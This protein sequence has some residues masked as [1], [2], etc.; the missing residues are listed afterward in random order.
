MPATE[1]LIL[2]DS[3]GLATFD[4]TLPE[5][6]RMLFDESER[7]CHARICAGRSPGEVSVGLVPSRDPERTGFC[8][9]AD[10]GPGVLSLA[11]AALSML[12][13]EVQEAFAYCR[14]MPEPAV[15]EVLD[16]FWLRDPSHVIGAEEIAAF[17][18]LF[19]EYMAGRPPEMVQGSYGDFS[20]P[21][22]SSVR[23]VS[24]DEGTLTI[25]EVETSD[26]FGLLWD[27]SRALSSCEL[28]ILSSEIQT[29]GGR[30]KDTFTVVEK[31][32]E[33]ISAERRLHIQATVLSTLEK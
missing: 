16:I 19:A 14:R 7:E 2:A 1:S 17:G 22:G 23:F 15:D 27:I 18:N 5:R 11:S 21:S 28:L 30:V 10:D 4:A 33:R 9:N 20:S 24:N 3:I 29:V 25:L 26:R 6:Y 32:G 13:F 31:S 8:L 12:E